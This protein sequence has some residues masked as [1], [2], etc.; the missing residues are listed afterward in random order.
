MPVI[1]LLNKTPDKRSEDFPPPPV[2]FPV[3]I[4]VDQSHTEDDGPL[5]N[6]IPTS[7][8]LKLHVSKTH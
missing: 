3:S 2:Q 4:S 8:P 6:V 7:S 1:I 5:R